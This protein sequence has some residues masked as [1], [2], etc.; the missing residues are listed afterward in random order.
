MENIFVTIAMQSI[1]IGAVLVCVVIL[2]GYVVRFV[3]SQ[4]LKGG[5]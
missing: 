1:L 4:F 3:F 2:I 5:S